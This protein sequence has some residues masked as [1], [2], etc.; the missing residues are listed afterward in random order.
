MSNIDEEELDEEFFTFPKELTSIQDPLERAENIALNLASL[1]KHLPAHYPA[2]L[3]YAQTLFT[4]E[5]LEEIRQTNPELATY[6]EKGEETA[7]RTASPNSVMDQ[8]VLEGSK[9]EINNAKTAVIIATENI[10]GPDTESKALNNVSKNKIIPKQST[11][12]VTDIDLSDYQKFTAE[13]IIKDNLIAV[14]AYQRNLEAAKF[15]ANKLQNSPNIDGANQTLEAGLDELIKVIPS[16]CEQAAI[17]RDNALRVFGEVKKQNSFNYNLIGLQDSAIQDIIKQHNL[18]SITLAKN[19]LT[20]AKDLLKQ[21]SERKIK[22]AEAV[23]NVEIEKAKAVSDDCL[24][25]AQ[26]IITHPAL[27]LSDF[28][29]QRLEPLPL[30]IKENMRDTILK[31]RGGEKATET[32]KAKSSKP[33]D[34][35]R[36]TNVKKFLGDQASL[37]IE[38]EVANYQQASADFTKIS[39]EYGEE[40]TK[41]RNQVIE[42]YM[43][44]YQKDFQQVK[45]SYE[46]E[47]GIFYQEMFKKEAALLNESQQYRSYLAA[48]KTTKAQR[49]KLKED[50]ITAVV[51]RAIKLNQLNE[52]L[53]DPAAKLTAN[54]LQ[55]C[56]VGSSVAILKK[57]NIPCD[58]YTEKLIAAHIKDSDNIRENALTEIPNSIEEKKSKMKQL[59][60]ELG[61]KEEVLTELTVAKTAERAA[62]QAAKKVVIGGGSPSGRAT[63]ALPNSIGKDYAAR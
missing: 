60:A 5:D 59:L 10:N 25:I 57:M 15:M 3:K 46:H 7:E 4:T 47:M 53:D 40:Q 42:E 28:N 12:L 50:I 54:E 23:C 55:E 29:M 44:K 9:E 56:M 38:Q 22:A 37:G 43:P 21:E 24:V 8:I 18:G 58:L 26:S 52:S 6:I 1:A 45:T 14:A 36:S 30:K 27:D 34:K 20:T 62:L 41:I 63:I 32:D 16:I 19:R 13:N 33:Q 2:A 48:E 61:I 51:I 35:P 11:S 39:T 49:E 17:P 31:I